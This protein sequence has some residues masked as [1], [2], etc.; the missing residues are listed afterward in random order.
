VEAASPAT[1]DLLHLGALLA[2]EP[3]PEEIFLESA[4]E[5]GDRLGPACSSRYAFTAM[6]SAAHRLSLLQRD[7]ESRTLMIHRL[8]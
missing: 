8:V 1:A 4:P 5:L 6:I 7:P 2:S 3:I